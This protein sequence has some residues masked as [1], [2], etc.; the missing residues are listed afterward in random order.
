MVKHDDYTASN[1]QIAAWGYYGMPRSVGSSNKKG[2]P[3]QAVGE[4]RYVIGWMADQMVRMGWRLTVDDNESWTLGL[5]DGQSVTSDSEQD[6]PEDPTHPA[7]ASRRLLEAVG[8]TDSTVRKVTTNL[9]VAGELW[10]IAEKNSDGKEVWTALSMVHSDLKKRV[11]KA[12]LK[13]HG[14]WPHPADENEPDAPLFGV[15]GIL[16]DIRWLTRLERSQSANRVAMRG[17]IGISDQLNIA[18]DATSPADASFWQR[19][20]SALSREMDDPEDVSPVGLVGPTELVKPEGSGMAGLSWLIPN[21]P[22]DERIDARLEK[23]VTRLAYGLPI[24]PEI[25]LGLQAQS[26]ATAFQVEGSAYRAHIEPA[27]WIVA[28]IPEDA[29]RSLLPDGVGRVRIIPDPTA[30]LARRHSIEDVLN[31]FDRGAV[32]FDYLREALG[33]PSRAEPTEEDLALWRI[34]KGQTVTVDGVADTDEGVA[35]DVPFTAAARAPEGE[36]EQTPVRQTRSDEE[37]GD[38][39]ERFDSLLLAELSGAAEQAVI[40]ARERLGAAIR[41]NPGYRSS[42]PAGLSNAEVAMQVGRDGLDTIGVDVDKTIEGAVSSTVQW[43]AERGRNAQLQLSQYLT[44]GGVEIEFQE[45]DSVRSAALLA[46]ALHAAVFTQVDMQALRG[47]I[48]A[49]G[50]Q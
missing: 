24:P 13:V 41:S 20:Q 6:D 10:Y 8:W 30:I 18:G 34:V 25:L 28:Q 48:S 42:V 47:V 27:A 15:L 35:D 40:K 38:R 45:T 26:R 37:L 3:D 11:E 17:I 49:L 22:Y 12:T 7:N 43:W 44:S 9:F 19:F 16:D 14:L 32:G 2:A 33:I 46:I 21:F 50:G 4:V 23:A 29:L 39:L 31:A 1:Q 5:P 36:T